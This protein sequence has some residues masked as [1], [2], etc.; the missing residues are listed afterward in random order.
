LNQSHAPA[1]LTSAEENRVIWLVV[2]VQFIHMV[3]FVMVMP[4]G[5][6][7]ARTINMDA[8]AIGI[9]GGVFTLAAAVSALAVYRFLD[10][11]NRRQSLLLAMIALAVTTA[12]T[13]LAW[14]YQSLLIFRVLAGLAAGPV[15]ALALATITDGVAV[16]RRGRAFG[17]VVAAFSASAVVGVP[18]GLELARVFSWPAAFYAVGAGGLLVAFCIYRYLPDVGAPSTRAALSFSQVAR[19][20]RHQ[21]GLGVMFVA[22]FSIFLL[23]PQLSGYWQFNLG[24]PREHLSL[25]YMAGGVTAF[26]LS[27]V[28]G[29]LVDSKGPMYAMVIFASGLIAIT[30][31]AFTLALAIPVVIIFVSYMGFAAARAVPSQMLSSMVPAPDQRAGY[32]ALQSATQS[33]GAGTGSVVSSMMV[34]ELADHRLVNIPQVSVVSIAF[35]MLLIWLCSLLQKELSGAQASIAE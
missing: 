4:L 6:D 3:D 19:S 22:V 31:F 30:F 11:F 13:G 34:R 16:E 21:L 12:T 27:G 20:R 35:L 26:L 5:P 28:S 29:K 25:L 33:L 17:L 32:M 1:S 7:F 18:L 14:S 8:S 15:T 2:A 24:F 23:I 10:R 9:V